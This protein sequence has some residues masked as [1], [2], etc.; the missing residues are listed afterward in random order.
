MYNV[1][2]FKSASSIAVVLL[3]TWN[4]TPGITVITTNSLIIRDVKGE[5]D[6]R[7]YWYFYIAVGLWTACYTVLL[8]FY[9]FIGIRD[10]PRLVRAVSYTHLTLPTIYSV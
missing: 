4:I 7:N 2:L 3:L 9:G 10:R 1:F 8:L 6:F 5:H